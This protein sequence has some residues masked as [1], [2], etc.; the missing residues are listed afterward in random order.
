MSGMWVIGLGLSAG[1]LMSKKAQLT[2]QLEKAEKEF[3]EAA[4]PADDGLRSDEIREVQRRVPDSERYLDM[5]L[6]DLSRAD[7][8]QLAK[9][10][11]EAAQGVVQYEAGVGVYPIEGVYLSFDNHG[12]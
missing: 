4:E 8:Q 12:V 1:Y 11:D 6:Q 10:R 2:N 3:N 5:N 7:V 9:A